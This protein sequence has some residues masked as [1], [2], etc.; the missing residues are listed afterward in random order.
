MAIKRKPVQSKEPISE[1]KLS[2]LGL[3]LGMDVKFACCIIALTAFFLAGFQYL[4]YFGKLPFFG[5]FAL[6]DTTKQIFD[7]RLD[8]INRI[9][10]G[11]DVLT[12]EFREATTDRVSMRQELMV[13]IDI[14]TNRTLA[15][16]IASNIVGI[17]MRMC[18]AIRVMHSGEADAYAVQLAELQRE[19]QGYTNTFYPVRIC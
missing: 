4:L 5:G 15:R 19:Y 10:N 11:V 2:F 8:M 16:I 9:Q 13:A 12:K 3:S 7:N 1:A 14:A 17:N 18:E 6:A